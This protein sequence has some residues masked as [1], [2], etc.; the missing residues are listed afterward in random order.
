MMTSTSFSLTQIRLKLTKINR[1]PSHPQTGPSHPHPLSPIIGRG[2]TNA[3]SPR[4][5]SPDGTPLPIMGEG[6]RGVGVREGDR[7]KVYYLFTF[8]P[9][10]DMALAANSL[11]YLPPRNIMQMEEDLALLPLWWCEEGDYIFTVTK[12]LWRVGAGYSLQKIDRDG[13]GTYRSV[14]GEGVIPC[15][16]GW[17]R[18]IRAEFA[19]IGVPLSL[20]P[21]EDDI[22]RYRSLSS[23]AFAAEYIHQFLDDADREG[24]G[25]LLV[26][27]GMRVENTPGPPPPH[28]LSPVIGRGVTNALSHA[29]QSGD[30][31]IRMVFPPNHGGGAGGEGPEESLIF[32]TLWS[33]SGRGV[34]V[35]HPDKPFNMK[36]VEASIRNQGG[37][38]VDDFYEDKL[39]DFALE[40][41]L[42]DT[43][44]EFLGYSVFE[45]S[46]SGNYGGNI[47]ASQSY[48]RDR[49]LST[50]ISEEFFDRVVESSLIHLRTMLLGRYTGVLG[51]DMLICR[52]EGQVKLHPC[53]EINLRRNMGILAIDVYKRLGDN[54]NA[55]L[56]GNAE[57]G[58]RAVVAPYPPSPSPMIGRGS[59]IRTDSQSRG[60]LL[61]I[62][63]G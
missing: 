18:S 8:N 50:G 27:R 52:H 6:G 39:L 9:S 33:S 34:F 57:H 26:G 61:L 53:I 19:R 41:S 14:V 48:L 7:E 3:I 51:I 17:S 45:A 22:E 12:E 42:T 4:S 47:V 49:I 24:W 59:T 1:G 23:R 38:L 54:A 58:F 31:S 43:D 16:W 35:Y 63:M 25:N 29:A 36:R 55:I 40:F 10:N 30:A 32:K 28:P 60:S 20:L 15:P 37:I 2:V 44:I 46:E 56:A 62:R 5:F 21:T 11:V 13:D